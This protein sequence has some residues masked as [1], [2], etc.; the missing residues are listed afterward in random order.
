MSR[1]TRWLSLSGVERRLTLRAWALVG[2]AVTQLA[3]RRH[4]GSG[5]GSVWIPVAHR[6]HDPVTVDAAVRRASAYVPGARCLAQALAAR[7]LIGGADR[8][9]IRY[10][11]IRDDR[12]PEGLR[13][14]AW[15]EMH[16]RRV[17]GD[18]PAPGAITLEGSGG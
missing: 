18:A 1:L 5:V 2:L 6:G 17:A 14:H 11:V 12:D 15:V 10:S 8:P 13:A 16:G 9:T 3:F 4:P 7:A